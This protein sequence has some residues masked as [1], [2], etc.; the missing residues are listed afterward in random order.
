[1]PDCC[2]NC[3]PKKARKMGSAEGGGFKNLSPSLLL[4]PQPHCRVTTIWH[5]VSRL[6][7][8]RRPTTHMLT[9]VLLTSWLG[10][11]DATPCCALLHALV[12]RL[13]R[14]IAVLYSYL[15]SHYCS[16]LC[17]QYAT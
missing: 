5:S 14:S 2:Y 1:M 11:F 13:L 4:S 9:R 17:H 6:Q 7:R 8:N 15:S 12:C 10:L 16:S 3:F